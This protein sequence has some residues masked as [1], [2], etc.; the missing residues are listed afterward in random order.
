[1][2]AATKICKHMLML[3]WYKWLLLASIWTACWLAPQPNYKSADKHMSSTTSTL[4]LN[5]NQPFFK[6]GILRSS[7]SKNWEFRIWQYSVRL[8]QLS[9]IGNCL[10]TYNWCEHSK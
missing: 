6:S 4:S 8:L 10:R 7:M 2:T 3:D 9:L 5:D 1:M